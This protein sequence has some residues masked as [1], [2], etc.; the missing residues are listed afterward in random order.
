[1]GISRTKIISSSSFNVRFVID[2]KHYL[3]LLAPYYN[4]PVEIALLAWLGLGNRFQQIPDDFIY[5]EDLETAVSAMEINDNIEEKQSTDQDENYE[6]ELNEEEEEQQPTDQDENYEDELNEEEEEEQRHRQNELDLE[7]YEDFPSSP[8]RKP[9]TIRVNRMDK[10]ILSKDES[11]RQTGRKKPDD[12]HQLIR[13]IIQIPTTLNDETVKQINADVWQLSMVQRHNL[14]RYWLLKYRQHLHR[15]IRHATQ[16]YN[17][18]IS[19][20]DEY[21]QE[22]DYHILKDSIIVAMTTTCAAKHHKILEKLRKK[23]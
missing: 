11:K 16:K 9:E 3:S 10:E 22:V 2:H 18:A 7:E 8:V 6:G 14:Y 19:A 17:Q 1:M 23:I 21:R 20:L 12:I 4:Y 15:Y 13:D 5:K